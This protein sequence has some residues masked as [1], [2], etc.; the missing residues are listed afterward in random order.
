ME[1]WVT[2]LII[3]G[4]LVVLFASGLPVAF[5]FMVINF[6]GTLF[7]MGG[8]RGLPIMVETVVSNIAVF[9]LVAVPMFILLGEILYRAGVATRMVSAISVWMGRVRGSLA[10][11]AVIAGVVFA[12][13]S[14]SSMSGVAVL[15]STLVPD[16]KKRGYSNEM[17]I[18][19]ILGAGGLAM[20]IPPSILMILLA[21]LAM[22]PADKALI[23][24]F[25]PG[26]VL[27]GLYAA[28]ILIRSY[29]QPQLAPAYVPAGVTWRE[30]ARSLV[31]ILPV[32]F[33]IF[34][35]LGLIFLGV[36]TPS[37]AAAI[38][39]IGAFILAFIYGGLTWQTF[40][41]SV[42]ETFKV[43]AMVF[44]IIMGSTTFSSL[45]AFTG[46][47]G[48]L[49]NLALAL[50][51]HPVVL[52][53]MMQ[54]IILIMGCFIDGISI[55]MITVPI[56][57]PII[58]TLGLDPLWFVVMTIVNIELGGITPPFGLLNFVM[59]GVLPDVDMMDIIK[60]GAPFVGLQIVGM[61]LMFAFPILVTWLPSVTG[62]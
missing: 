23:G 31:F 43:T 45:L 53:I 34:L 16:M 57:M 29:I 25:I 40:T 56:Y 33:I 44:L 1:W 38:G 61:A 8:V 5:A 27:A 51:V 42:S 46:A 50:P 58:R 7:L 55:M 41:A 4:A 59:K 54:F 15:G 36:T 21:T 13:M 62:K 19:P 12:M 35:V 20:I 26:L 11:I 22:V 3:I 14:G 49:T 52:V 28:Y 32:G 17:S 10:L 6:V 39:A 9:S 37:E 18:G 30:R 2:L 47:T 48:G 60:A 24:G